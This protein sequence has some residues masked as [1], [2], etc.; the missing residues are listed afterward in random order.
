MW[1]RPARLSY[2]R[3]MRRHIMLFSAA[4]LCLSLASSARASSPIS[5]EARL[6]FEAGV[7]LLQDPDGA[8]FEEAYREFKT[9]Y[10]ATPS[11]KILGN[12]GICAMKLERDSE[13]ID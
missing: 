3:V 12:L 4:A 10:A 7:N 9:A 8:R 5:E 13:A 6:H 1:W 11:W 2:R